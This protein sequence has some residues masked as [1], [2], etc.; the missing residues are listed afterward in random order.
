V[1]Y[2]YVTEKINY[3][4]YAA[5][6]VLYTQ[7]GMTSFPVRLASEIFQRCAALLNKRRLT[8]YD[9]CAGSAYLLTVLGFLHS[10]RISAL[11]AGDIHTDAAVIA[12][13]NLSLLIESGL[14]QRQHEIE[15][16]LHE[17]GKASHAEALTSVD[18][19]RGQLP[20]QAIQSHVWS[21]DAMQPPLMPNCVDVLL[22]DVPYGDVV[23]WGG[24]V[25]DN[26]IYELLEAH[27]RIL[28][29]PSVV[30]IISD[31][32]QKA[33]HPQYK[34]LLQDTLGKR[35]ITLLQPIG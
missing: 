21:G 31:K 11:W 27:Y 18:G 23:S 1:Q 26:P 28:A 12:Q 2:E 32:G 7:A 17:Y 15:T 33:A 4:V 13:R 16:M 29:R 34:R 19:L 14:E 30:A 35:R 20:Q 10:G 5:G 24:T 9:P 6:R 22:T 8:V 25:T 3:E